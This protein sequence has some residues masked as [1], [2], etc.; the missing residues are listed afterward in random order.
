MW[1]IYSI[2]Y[3]SAIEKNTIMLFVATEIQL[4]IIIVSE[5]S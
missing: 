1:Y 2:E 3:Y 5:V 4:E